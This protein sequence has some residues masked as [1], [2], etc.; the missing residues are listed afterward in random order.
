MR[1]GHGEAHAFQQ[2]RDRWG[3]RLGCRAA[4]GRG[5]RGGSGSRGRGGFWYSPDICR[6][7]ASVS[8]EGVSTTGFRRCVQDAETG[9]RYARFAFITINEAESVG[10]ASIGSVRAAGIRH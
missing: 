4:V 9:V 1:I 5:G 7:A 10:S 3:A 8:T 2:A 6:S